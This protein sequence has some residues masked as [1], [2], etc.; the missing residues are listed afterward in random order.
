MKLFPLPNKSPSE[1]QSQLPLP[2]ICI[3]SDQP[4]PGPW[5][6]TPFSNYFLLPPPSTVVNASLKMASNLCCGIPVWELGLPFPRVSTFRGSQIVGLAKLV[7]PSGACPFGWLLSFPGY[8]FQQGSVT[9]VP[10]PSSGQGEKSMKRTR[11]SPL[12]CLH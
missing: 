12:H 2:Q 7:P 8:Y 10:A 6:D 3:R 4:V 9:W 11:E 5:A 1:R